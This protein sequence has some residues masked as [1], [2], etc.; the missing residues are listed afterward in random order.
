MKICWVF[1]CLSEKNKKKEVQGNCS[2]GV[3][4]DLVYKSHDLN[5]A[6]QNLH[7]SWMGFC[8]PYFQHSTVWWKG[9][10]RESPGSSWPLSL[11]Y[12]EQQRQQKERCLKAKRKERTGPQW[13]GLPSAH[14]IYA[15]ALVCPHLYTRINI[16]YPPTPPNT[17]ARTHADT[18]FK[19]RTTTSTK[20]MRGQGGERVNQN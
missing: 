5:L 11:A 13:P 12:T 2:L 10:V 9:E 4:G 3:G 19:K 6:P 18:Q 14:H 8:A 1:V 7:R 15:T 17:D 20:I 16:Q